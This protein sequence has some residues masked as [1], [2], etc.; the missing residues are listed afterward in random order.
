MTLYQTL[1][2]HYPFF[3]I[4]VPVALAIERFKRWLIK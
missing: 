3:M 2:D 1:K 4:L